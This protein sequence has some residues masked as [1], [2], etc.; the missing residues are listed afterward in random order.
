MKIENQ[1]CTL[2]QALKLMQLGVKQE[3]GNCFAYIK[4]RCRDETEFYL[5]PVC[6]P[7]CSNQGY[8]EHGK[9]CL[10]GFAAFTVAELGVML[11]HFDN[12]AQMG[13]FMHL[14][15]FD[16]SAKDGK[17]WYCVWEYDRDKENAG[18][19]REIIDAPTE[20]EARTAALIYA[21]ENNL[22]T[23]EEVNHRL[24]Q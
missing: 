2:E 3:G 20:A 17:G 7:G 1:V 11:P 19:G 9:G 10:D 15:V 4:N 13:G 6:Y 12:L 5:T 21:I 16:P 18:F 23:P 22:T 14:T 24:K 8:S